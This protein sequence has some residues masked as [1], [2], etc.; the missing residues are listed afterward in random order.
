M[1]ILILSPKQKT[2]QKNRKNKKE[3]NSI[4]ISRMNDS[5]VY[6]IRRIDVTEALKSALNS[7]NYQI[8]HVTQLN[9]NSF[10][11]GSVWIMN[12]IHSEIK[13]KK[14]NSQNEKTV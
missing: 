14:L 5:S 9:H 13:R 6:R 12:K 2:A 11:F 10:W 7:W 1:D 4:G 8:I 3:I